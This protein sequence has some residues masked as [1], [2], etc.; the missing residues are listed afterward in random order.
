M[1]YDGL[2]TTVSSCE[3]FFGAVVVVEGRTTVVVSF[4][5]SSS[6]KE[7]HSSSRTRED[8]N[9]EIVGN[10]NQINLRVKYDEDWHARTTYDM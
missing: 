7:N 2:S 3:P 6:L 9:K 4:S 5:L 1:S 10:K 8:Q